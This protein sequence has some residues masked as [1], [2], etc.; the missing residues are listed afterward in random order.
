MLLSRIRPPEHGDNS[1]RDAKS[2]V[3]KKFRW[4]IIIG[5]YPPGLL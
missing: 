3:V 4:A 1:G 2:F 5:F